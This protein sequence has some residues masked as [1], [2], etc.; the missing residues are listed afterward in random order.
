[1]WLSSE[2]IKQRCVNVNPLCGLFGFRGDCRRA[3]DLQTMVQKDQV[4]ER[5]RNSDVPIIVNPRPKVDDC[6][7]SHVTSSRVS[8]DVATWSAVRRSPR[9][10]P[11]PETPDARAGGP[12][13]ARR[14]ARYGEPACVIAHD[15]FYHAHTGSMPHASW[16]WLVHWTPRSSACRPG[17]RPPFGRSPLCSPHPSPHGRPPRSMPPVCA[18]TWSRRGAGARM[19]I[20]RGVLESSW[21]LTG[22]G[23]F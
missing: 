22:C 23:W 3:A 7:L 17:P 2:K 18:D 10:R 9:V 12:P 8:R 11:V 19:S 21:A 20:P 6:G 15:D 4:Q 16:L 5:V 14:G 1:M 13:R